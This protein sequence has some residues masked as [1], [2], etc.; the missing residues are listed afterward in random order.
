M[1]AE[2]ATPQDHMHTLAGYILIPRAAWMSIPRG[3]KIIT[4]SGATPSQPMYLSSVQD[5]PAGT[6]LVVCEKPISRGKINATTISADGITELWKYIPDTC[7]MELLILMDVIHGQTQS[8]NVLQNK[9]EEMRG[10]ITRMSESAANESSQTTI[11]DSAFQRRVSTLESSVA[12]ARR[13]IADVH[14]QMESLARLTKSLLSAQTPPATNTRV[15]TAAPLRTTPGEI[16][17]EFGDQF[18]TR[19]AQRHQHID[20]GRNRRSTTDRMWTP[21]EW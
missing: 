11:R 6:I 2:D 5:T 13:E 12:D 7:Q 4:M 16:V 21:D 14:R 19:T 17:Q 18:G 8:L 20:R 9:T 1:S 3:A 10:S 15:P